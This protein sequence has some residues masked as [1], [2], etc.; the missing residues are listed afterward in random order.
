MLNI[1]VSHEQTTD[2]TKYV[3]HIISKVLD[4]GLEC[5]IIAFRR[6][7]IEKNVYYIIYCSFKI[8]EET[9]SFL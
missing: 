4:Y 2:L 8:F 1:K 6:V 3:N 9:Y 7:G 5:Y